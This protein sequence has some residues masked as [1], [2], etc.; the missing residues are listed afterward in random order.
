MQ[1]RRQRRPPTWDLAPSR[2]GVPSLAAAVQGSP[3]AAAAFDAGAFAPSPPGGDENM[4]LDP[5]GHLIVLQ[6]HS[7]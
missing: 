2:L 1:T 3:A 5:H 7:R 6:C 4:V